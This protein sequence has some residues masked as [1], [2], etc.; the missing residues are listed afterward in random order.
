MGE[1]RRAEFAAFGWNPDDVPDPQDPATFE[2]SK[3][4]WSERSRPPHAE[5]LAWYRALLD[6]RRRSPDLGTGPLGS[7]TTRWSEDPAWL[8]IERG[9]VTVLTNLSGDPVVLDIDR[10]RP[11]GVLLASRPGI[12]PTADG[13][14]ELP[15]DSVVVLGEIESRR[16][17]N[18]AE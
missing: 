7:V 16:R 18:S 8:V 14:V 6:L 9:A 10:S 12:A 4:D 5:L 3:L 1:G 11:A 13:T 2:R 15:P 17:V